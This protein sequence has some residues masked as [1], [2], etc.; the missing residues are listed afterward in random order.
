MKKAQ[1]YKNIS[2]LYRL[3]ITAYYALQTSGVEYT[4]AKYNNRVLTKPNKNCIICKSDL[5]I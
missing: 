5:V 3:E 4:I 1:E 2:S